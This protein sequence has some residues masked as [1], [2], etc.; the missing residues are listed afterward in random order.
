MKFSSLAATTAVF[1]IFIAG[2]GFQ[3]A[4]ADWLTSSIGLGLGSTTQLGS[5]PAK[6]QHLTAV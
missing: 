6:P 1:V 4:H 3:A 5:R 2:F